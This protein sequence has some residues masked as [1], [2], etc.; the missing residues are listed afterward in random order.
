MRYF[1]ILAF[2]IF[3]TLANAGPF[4]QCKG[5]FAGG[6]PPKVNKSSVQDVCFDSFAVLYSPQTKTA[7]YSAEKLNRDRLMDALDEQRTDEFYEEARLPFGA[8]AT[9]NDYRGSG[10]DRGH[11][12]PAGDMPNRNAMSQSFSLANVIPQNATNNRKGWANIEKATRKFAMRAKGDVY[13]LTGPAYGNNPKSIGDS[14]LVPDY[15]W[16][17]VYDEAGG[18]AWAYWVPNEPFTGGVKPISY[19]ELKSRISLDLLPGITLKGG[20]N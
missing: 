17:L 12:A 19:D 13:V 18:R 11:L 2:A 5:Y 6:N 15:I 3:S 8:R 16:K 9:L 4:D 1:L 14:V 7:I 10:Y 20:L